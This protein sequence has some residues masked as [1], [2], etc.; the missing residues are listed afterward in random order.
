MSHPPASELTQKASAEMSRGPL[1]ICLK[2]T[3]SSADSESQR[4]VFGEKV[5]LAKRPYWIE[6]EERT[7]SCH[8]AF[9]WMNFSQ[10][11]LVDGKAVVSYPSMAGV[12]NS[13]AG[14]LPS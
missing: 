4:R 12:A 8:T 10:R 2:T 13:A 9:L 7:S 11:S 1:N 3:C 5:K 6:K 14:G